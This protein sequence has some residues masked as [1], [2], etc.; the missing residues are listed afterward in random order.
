MNERKEE[1]GISAL[2]RYCALRHSNG[3]S[4]TSGAAIGNDTTRLHSHY[5]ESMRT[6]LRNSTNIAH[7]VNVTK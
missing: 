2:R 7:N 6:A 1:R 3:N 5:Y 4:V